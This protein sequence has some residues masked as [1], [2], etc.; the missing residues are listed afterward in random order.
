MMF[1]NETLYELLCYYVSMRGYVTEIIQRRRAV[2]ERVIGTELIPVVD[3]RPRRAEFRDGP[4]WVYD[5]A[6]GQLHDGQVNRLAAYAA[7]RNGVSYE[8]MR[9]LL[10]RQGLTVRADDVMVVET[11]DADGGIGRLLFGVYHG[12]PGWAFMPGS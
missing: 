4:A 8:E 1:H 10:Q 11:A 12:A 6:L 3:I 2:W 9:S 5:V 7:R